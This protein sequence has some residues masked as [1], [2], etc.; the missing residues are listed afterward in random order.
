MFMEDK[1]M[2]ERLTE[3]TRRVVLQAQQEAKELGE[4]MVGTEHLL[5]GLTCNIECVAIQVLDRMGIHPRRIRDDVMRQV[6][7]HG[8]LDQNEGVQFTPRSKKVVELAYGQALRL[9]SRFIGT[10][11]LLLGLIEEGDGMAAR[12]LVKLGADLGLT[13]V[14]LS[15]LE[16]PDINQVATLVIALAALSSEQKNMMATSVGLRIT[17]LPPELQ[18]RIEG[19]VDNPQAKFLPEDARINSRTVEGKTTYVV[20]LPIEV[21]LE[22]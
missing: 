12:V 10:E 14:A 17:T 3:Q 5:L 19:Q 9:G 15:N 18:A 2:W 22:Q 8:S 21:T 1:K 13:L 11:H 20:Y 6:I 16:A 4:R 7:L